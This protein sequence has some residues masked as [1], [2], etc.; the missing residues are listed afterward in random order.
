MASGK[1][2]QQYWKRWFPE[3]WLQPLECN[4]LNCYFDWYLP[5]SSLKHD[6]NRSDANGLAIIRMRC[7]SSFL[8]HALAIRR[9]S[10]KFKLDS[11]R[12]NC[13]PIYLF[14]HPMGNRTVIHILLR[15][16]ALAL[17]IVFLSPLVLGV[18][19]GLGAII[20]DKECE[21]I[22]LAVM[23]S[24]NV[25]KARCPS[26]ASESAP[27]QQYLER[28]SAAHLRRMN[29][30]D[31]DKDHKVFSH[32]DL[33]WNHL[34]TLLRSIATPVIAKPSQEISEGI[35]GL[36][37]EIATPGSRDLARWPY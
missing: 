28:P 31:H 8:D 25:I 10:N 26:T 21:V 30:R 9:K 15:W 24:R 2:R 4:G 19:V 20:G 5:S 3:I 22:V 1:S 32:V 34:G 27:E 7:L 17:C 33:N 13:D 18:I 36:Q 29:N 35:K 14:L 23:W 6:C 37:F 12:Y 16:A 11:S